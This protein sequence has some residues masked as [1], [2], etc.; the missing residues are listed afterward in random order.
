MNGVLKVYLSWKTGS[1]RMS[2]QILIFFILLLLSVQGVGQVTIEGV[3]VDKKSKQPLAF[4]NILSE[5]GKK[6]VVT[7]CGGLLAWG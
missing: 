4:V 7:D 2:K 5:S 1:E 6:G 3:V